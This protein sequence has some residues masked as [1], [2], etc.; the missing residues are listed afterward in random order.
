MRFLRRNLKARIVTY[1]LVPSSLVV[2]VLSIL[3][4]LVARDCQGRCENVPAGCRCPAKT[5]WLTGQQKCHIH[6]MENVTLNPK[7]QARLQVLN[8]LL[9][10]HM[11]LDQ[12]AT[13]MGVSPRHTRRILAAYREKGAAAVAHGHRGRKPPNATPEPVATAVV[14]LAR[15]RYAGTNHTHLSELLSDRDGIDIGRTTLRRILVNAGLSSPR[16]RR[17]PKHRVRRQR[18]PRQGMLIQMDGSHHP[19]LGDRIPPFTLLIAVDDATGTVVDA[20]FCE[21]ED[22]HSYFLLIQRLLQHRGIPL[23]LYT[24]RHGV[25]RHTPGSGLPGMPTQ[26]SRA[27]DELGIQM[28][29]ALSP[30]A[31]GRVERME[32]TFQDRL[33]TELRLA[34]ASSIGEANSVLEQFLPRFNRRFRVPPQ[35]P[36]PAFRPLDPELCL[37]QILCFKHRRKV[38]RDNTVRFQLHTL[39]LLPERERPSYAGAA[40]EVLQG[41]AG[42]LSVRHEGRIIS[43]QEA[44]PSPVFLRNGHGGSESVPVRSSSA[45]GLGE[46]WIS[47]LEP[48]DSR[49]EDE[50]GGG[51]ITDGAAT[52]GRPA[53]APTRKPTFLQ[54]ERWK[55][56]QKARRKGMS[57]RAIERELGIHRATIKKY[58]D[59]EGPPT[60]QSRVV[61]ETSSSD[62]IE[63]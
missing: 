24:D 56:I 33:V 16:R 10:E 61:S 1:F 50:N 60:R 15:T 59:A 54:K 3:A 52:P 29:F 46:H 39:Q 8:S 51:L 31:K 17:Q 34:G 18:M 6:S 35:H 20:L 40:V 14:H 62:T 48:L 4:F 22:A 21:K 58:T 32:E 53:A 45:N 30:Q 2:A 43:S 44:P 47:T 23:A 19:W 27:M 38:A 26:F 55:A 11:T 42:R 49:A 5:S 13:L 7:E 12:A 28:I 36:E 57:L 63:A 41:L 37:E 25:F 9:A